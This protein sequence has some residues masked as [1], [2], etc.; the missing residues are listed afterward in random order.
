M[1]H[2]PPKKK[3]LVDWKHRKKEEVNKKDKNAG[4]YKCAG[5]GKD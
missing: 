3:V 5:E 1:N 2:S 4:F